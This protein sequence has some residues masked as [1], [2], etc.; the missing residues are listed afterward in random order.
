MPAGDQAGSR[1][2]RHQV[3]LRRRHFIELDADLFDPLAVRLGLGQRILEFLVVDDAALL[4]VDQEHLARLQTPFL[5]DLLFRN[6]QHAGLGG[7]DHEVV[8]GDQIAR[9][10]QAVTVERR[11]NLA[12]VGEGHGSGAIPRLHHRSVIFVESA[13]VFVHQR[14][15][16]PGL[17]NH[18]HHGMRH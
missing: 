17:R 1:E 10:A 12:A 16:F 15:L 6:R 3:F 9:R 2:L 18:Q 8:I 14:V 11:A 7:H 13:T 4:H 5:D